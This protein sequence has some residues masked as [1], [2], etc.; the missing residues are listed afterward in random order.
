MRSKRIVGTVLSVLGVLLLAAAGVLHWAVVPNKAQLPADTNKTRQYSGTAKVLINAQALALGDRQRGV[1]TNVPVQ[2]TQVIKALATSGSVAQVS[3]AKTLS[4]AG[5]AVGATQSTYAVNRKS[6]EATTDHPSHWSV[7]AAQGLTVSFPIGSKQQNYTGWVSDT[8]TTTELR[9]V[10]QESRDGVSTYVYQA[11]V[12]STAIKDPQILS[13][14]PPS[15]PTNVLGTLGASLSLPDQLKAQL[16]QVLPQLPN[17]VPLSYTYSSTATYWVEPT[18]GTVV[19]VQQEEIRSAE[20]ALPAGVSPRVPV[21]DVSTRGTDASVASATSEASHDA[22]KINLY[23][24][25]L[26]LILLVVGAVLLVV[27]IVLLV[28]GRRPPLA[29][30]SPISPISSTG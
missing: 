2:A 25:T 21:Y 28:L 4:A 7:V 12:P 17:P 14:L 1:L 16:A 18:T 15:L 30:V 8:R 24:R 5:Q 27:G 13:G 11:S 26:P 9:Y 23:G 29:S 10:R 19:D 20:L 3:N 6:L 22:H